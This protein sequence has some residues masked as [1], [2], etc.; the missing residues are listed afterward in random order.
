MPFMKCRVNVPVVS[1]KENLLKNLLGQAVQ[2]FPGITEEHLLLVLED[3]STIYLRGE[4][5]IPVAY[6]EVSVFGNNQHFFYAEF[7]KAVIKIFQEVLEISPKNIFVSYFDIDGFGVDK[8]Y[9]DR[10][11]K[12]A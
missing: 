9:F 10:N 12:N 5:N 4:K 7:S 3:N 1:D 2:I 8:F 11:D 6:I